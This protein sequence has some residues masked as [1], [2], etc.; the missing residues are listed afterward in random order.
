MNQV[1]GEP[2]LNHARAISVVQQLEIRYSLGGLLLADERE[3]LKLAIEALA[4]RAN[5]LD[6]IR[7]TVDQFLQS[8]VDAKRPS[9][10][11]NWYA[12]LLLVAAGSHSD[13][14]ATM[15]VV[16]GEPISYRELAGAER[17]GATAIRN[18]NQMR[19][20]LKQARAELQP[21]GQTSIERT[22]HLLQR[23][24]AVLAQVREVG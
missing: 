14:I 24:D 9:I 11:W 18:V 3:A 17:A 2:M 20:L 23:I 8:V 4:F 6:S 7:A 10:P 21:Q 13:N 19:L 5:F 16:G 22:F 15:G 12:E 1:N